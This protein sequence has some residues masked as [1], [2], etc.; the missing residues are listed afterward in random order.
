[1]ATQGTPS[2]DGVRG[3]VHAMWAG[4]ADGW[5]ENADYVDERSAALTA[6][7]LARSA[8]VPGDRVLELACGPGGA[9]LA[10]AERVGPAGEVVLSDVA[11]EMTAIAAARAGARGLGNVRTAIRDLER[12]DE[13]DAGYDVVLCREGL[14]F[15]FAPERAAGEI[16]RVLRPGGRVAAAVWGTRE[17]NPWLG[18]V[19]DAVGAQTGSPVPPPGVP[20]PFSLADPDRLGAL[21]AGAGLVGVAVEEVPVP[22]RSPS[23]E[24]WW[25]RTSA[26]AGPVGS[27]VAGLP[28]DARAAIT[29]R[30]REAVAAYATPAGI[31]LPGVS[32]LA[33]ARRPG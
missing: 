31:E 7:M 16:A 19:L 27:L 20:G 22:L 1:M 14:M 24:D 10:A 12:I 4:V 25:A 29:A 11:A 8:P 3:F 23:F 6:Q 17:R 26:V 28:G 9:G 5:G 13:P 15:A 33:S 32:L 30:L 2:D 18:L 21:L